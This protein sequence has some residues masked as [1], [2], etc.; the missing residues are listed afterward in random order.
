MNTK[1][2][3]SMKTIL[4]I[5]G[6]SGIGEAFARRF[7]SQGKKVIVTGRREARLKELKNSLEGLETY[8]FD[9][10]D[11]PAISKHVEELFK[12]FPNIDTVW[13]NAG[14]QIM[15]N[16]TDLSSSTDQKVIDEIT[17]NVT[18][19]LIAARH[20]VPKLIAQKSPTTFMITS[21]G[22]AFVPA[23]SMFSVYCA[24]KA[25]VHLYMVG[26]RQALKE[27]KVNVIEIVP[28]YTSGTE[29]DREHKDQVGHLK[30]LPMEALLDQVCKQL[31]EGKG[32]ELKE[33]AAGSAVQRVTGWRDGIG[34]L[35]TQLGG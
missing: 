5:G 11:L 34:P 15:S 4:I 27:T 32:K 17:T 3:A 28:P 2:S 30:P 6:T 20:V 33:V 18:A 25:A 22:L 10:S 8:A 29:L 16:P 14:V 19:P 31:E 7:Q 35:L 9:I 1:M 23:G 26:L 13:V 24:T 12:L 21:S